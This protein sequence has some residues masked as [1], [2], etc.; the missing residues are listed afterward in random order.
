MTTPPVA[1]CP[2]C[3][4]MSLQAVAVSKKD[5]GN[6]LMAEFMLGTAAGVAAGSKTIIQTACLNCGCQYF[7]GSADEKRLRILSGQ[8]GEA[9]KKTLEDG[10]RMKREATSKA[11]DR[12]SHTILLSVFSFILLWAIVW[13]V[14][15]YCA[16][17]Q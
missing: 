12:T 17:P 11:N 1:T 13:T 8:L 16:G 3:G 14:G 9:A 7:P 6:A 10:E 15:S 2:K 5:L 4:S